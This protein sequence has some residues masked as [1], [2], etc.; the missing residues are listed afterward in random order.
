MIPS[1]HH[2]FVSSFVLWADNYIL[3]KGQAYSNK[4]SLFYIGDDPRVPSDQHVYASPYKQWVSDSSIAGATIPTSITI[5]SIER[6]RS[7][8]VNFDFDNGRVLLDDDFVTPDVVSGSYSVKDFS[9]YY[10]ND[11]EEDLIIDNKYKPNHSIYDGVET[12]I[13]PYDQVVPAIFISVPMSKNE[14]FCFG[15]MDKSVLMAKMVILSDDLFKLDGALSLFS[16]SS[17][18]T[19]KQ[20]SFEDYPFEV[21][22]DLKNDNYNYT[23]L[24]DQSSELYYIEEAVASKL[25]DKIKRSLLNDLFVGFVDFQISTHRYPRS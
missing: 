22:G 14:P 16:D 1:F 19:F 17:Q 7:D 25:T 2:D 4:S 8:G 24:V 3:D 21:F 20:V 6:D 15:G 11:T 9:I 23:G 12:G 18:R 5:D 10:S 13:A